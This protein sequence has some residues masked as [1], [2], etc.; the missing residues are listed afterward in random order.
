MRGQSA[1]SGRT[2]THLVAVDWRLRVPPQLHGCPALTEAVGGLTGVVSK[3]LL[4]HAGNGQLVLPALRAADV[5]SLQVQPHVVLVPD[6]LRRGLGVDEADEGRLVTCTTFHQLVDSVHVRRVQHV[7]VDLVSGRLSHPIGGPAEV[8]AAGRPADGVE[9]EDRAL[10]VEAV[11]HRADVALPVPAP[12]HRRPRVAV[13][14][15]N[16]KDVNTNISDSGR[17]L[18]SRLTLAPLLTTI[19]PFGGSGWTVGGTEG[20]TEVSARLQARP[21]L[22]SPLCGP[23]PGAGQ[24]PAPPRTCTDLRHGLQPR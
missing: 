23:R 16:K 24:C 1:E 15:D 11:L 22:G 8:E 7:Q 4:S 10:V 6:Q 20:E 9:G 13:N 18:H 21:H 14:C 19:S 17:P 5:A 2:E 12:L 3:V